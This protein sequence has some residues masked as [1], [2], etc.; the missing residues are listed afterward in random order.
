MIKQQKTEI[1][2]RRAVF[3]VCYVCQNRSLETREV[4]K[5][6]N[7][8]IWASR[9]HYV[10]TISTLFHCLDELLSFTLTAE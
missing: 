6:V 9:S 1:N 10:E 7:I 4:G 5:Q 3:R 8:N 2:E